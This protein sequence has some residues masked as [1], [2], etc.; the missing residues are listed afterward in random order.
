L[1]EKRLLGEQWQECVQSG[2]V[3]LGGRELDSGA[4]QS[5]AAEESNSLPLS[6]NSLPLAFSFLSLAFSCLS[7]SVLLSISFVRFSDSSERLFA[8]SILLST[9]GSRRQ[10]SIDN[11]NRQR[12]KDESD[13][14]LLVE[15]EPG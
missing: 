5:F 8:S 14:P 2:A 12:G 1:I 7:S 13:A 9:S 11:H 4:E 3:E 10:L 6:F 15:L